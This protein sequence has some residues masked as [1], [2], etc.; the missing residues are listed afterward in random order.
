MSYLDEIFFQ[1]SIKTSVYQVRALT[2]LALMTSIA[3]LASVRQDGG[4]PPVTQVIVINEH[5]T[6]SSIKKEQREVL[7]TL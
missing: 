5:S 6:G 1:I 2:A 4:G 3:F 7:I